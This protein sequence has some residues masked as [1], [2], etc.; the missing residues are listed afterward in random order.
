M[1]HGEEELVPD[2]GEM[3]MEGFG[4]PGAAVASDTHGPSE[5]AM[6]DLDE[7]VSELLRQEGGGQ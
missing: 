7:D 5:E 3:G 1:S 2:L 6:R 4:Q